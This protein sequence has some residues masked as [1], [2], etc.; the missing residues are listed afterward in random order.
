MI[1]S[2]PGRSKRTAIHLLSMA[3]HL[4]IANLFH[5]IFS[6]IGS[7]VR[8]AVFGCFFFIVLKE[9]FLL[10]EADKPVIVVHFLIRFISKS[11][12]E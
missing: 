6:L 9:G 11:N 8:F 12:E 2:F 3:I 1:I 7:A 10:E 5:L 4:V